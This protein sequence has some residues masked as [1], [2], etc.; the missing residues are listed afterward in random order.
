M[1]AG[2][3]STMSGRSAIRSMS[4]KMVDKRSSRTHRTRFRSTSAS[5]KLRANSRRWSRDLSGTLTSRSIFW[6]RA[7]TS[8]ASAG[9][10]S[11][12]IRRPCFLAF[13]DTIARPAAVFG[14]VLR[15][16]FK[17]FACIF[18]LLSMHQRSA[19]LSALPIHTK[20]GVFICND[21]IQAVHRI[22]VLVGIDVI[23]DHSQNDTRFVT[24]CSP[25]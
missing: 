1:K 12:G 23:L 16:A 13:R 19:P 24:V 20:C 7:S 6:A 14:P 18:D 10:D 22:D 21:R 4:A 2:N 8:A 9:L 15:V 17:R 3:R 11:T 5:A 25:V